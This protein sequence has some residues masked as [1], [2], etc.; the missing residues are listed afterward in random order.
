MHFLK[1]HFALLLRCVDLLPRRQRG[2]ADYETKAFPCETVLFFPCKHP[3]QTLSPHIVRR[4]TF[5]AGRS[6][7]PSTVVSLQ[8]FSFLLWQLNVSTPGSR[9]A[10]H[11]FPR[12]LRNVKRCSLWFD[13]V[14]LIQALRLQ[15]GLKPGSPH[16]DV[17]MECI[18]THR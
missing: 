15:R 3:A 1:K 10:L 17:C 13:C 6:L 4:E 9:E 2:S 7:F 11:R 5:C 18:L 16:V 14:V 12:T 8:R